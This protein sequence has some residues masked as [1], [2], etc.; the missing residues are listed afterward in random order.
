MD[1][2]LLEKRQQ[3]VQLLSTVHYEAE[4]NICARLAIATMSLIV[5]T[6]V[7]YPNAKKKELQKINKDNV[8]YLL[9]ARKGLEQVP[10]INLVSCPEKTVVKKK[11]WQ[12]ILRR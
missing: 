3:L 4:T 2:E 11:W 10:L 6:P 5:S 8:E 12:Q 1:N 7:L 9:E